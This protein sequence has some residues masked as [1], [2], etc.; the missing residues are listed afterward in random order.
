MRVGP[1]LLA[2]LFAAALGV[3]SEGLA[4]AQGSPP[5]EAPDRATAARGTALLGGIRPVPPEASP[6]LAEGAATSHVLLSTILEQGNA[7]LK[8]P[9]GKTRYDFGSVTFITCSA[10]A[11][12]LEIEAMLQA[13]QNKA[14]GN[15]WDICADIDGKSA[16]L[17]CPYQGTLPTNGSYVSG[18]YAW[19]APLKKGTHTV[20]ATSFVTAPAG[21]A[22]YHLAYRLY[23]P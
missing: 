9:K 8:L 21:L 17:T 2:W 16:L 22:N 11:C 4:R 7:N 6:V 19:S 13:G 23:K 5:A 14:A 10:A 12:T 15:L 3:V 1:L 18:H 20:Q